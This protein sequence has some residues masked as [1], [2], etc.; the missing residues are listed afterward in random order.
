MRTEYY[1]NGQ[2][3]DLG[4]YLGADIY[5]KHQRL[6]AKKAKQY[7]EKHPKEIEKAIAFGRLCDGR[8]SGNRQNENNEK[9]SAWLL[10]YYM[11]TSEGKKIE[12]GFHQ[13]YKNEVRKQAGC[14]V[15]FYILLIVFIIIMF[16]T[17]FFGCNR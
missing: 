10:S 13:N 7:Y 2:K 12:E 3:A 11:E 6:L 9:I 8:S 16:A 5:N 14:G 1:V 15:L 4:S 17:N